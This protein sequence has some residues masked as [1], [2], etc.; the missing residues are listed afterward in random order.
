[1]GYLIAFIGL[2]L[3]LILFFAIVPHLRSGRSDFSGR[4]E[5]RHT[6]PHAE[7]EQ[8]EGPQEEFVSNSARPS[9]DGSD[10]QP[11]RS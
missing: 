4:G 5:A 2:A 7:K 6:D 9:I 11:P 10:D 1:M 3:F 8:M